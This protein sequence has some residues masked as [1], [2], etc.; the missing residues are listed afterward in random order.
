MRYLTRPQ[1]DQRMTAMRL[2]REGHTIQGVAHAI[3]AT[4]PAVD[5]WLTEWQIIRRCSNCGII[6]EPA[7]HELCE[8][9]RRVREGGSWLGHMPLPTVEGEPVNLREIFGNA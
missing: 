1:L 2:Y 7:E 4:V 9:C 8:V 6:L 3:G 5:K